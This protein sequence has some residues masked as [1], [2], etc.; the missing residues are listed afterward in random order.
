M[1]HPS[2]RPELLTGAVLALL[3]SRLLGRPIAPPQG[4]QAWH[5][6]ALAGFGAVHYIAVISLLRANERGHHRSGLGDRILHPA[7]RRRRRHRPVRR[8]GHHLVA[9]E[10]RA[11]R[12]L[13]G[14]D[15]RRQP[16]GRRGHATPA[17]AG[18]F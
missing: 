2:W 17:P 15:R 9:A 10:R 11:H 6:V 1:S 4:F 5:I 16:G 3:M 14:G 18:V 8:A 7:H 12:G 13:D